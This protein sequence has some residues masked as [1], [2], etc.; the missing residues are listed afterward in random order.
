MTRKYIHGVW[1][2]RYWDYTADEF[3][4]IIKGYDDNDFPIDNLVMD[5]GWHT[6]DATVGTGHNAH[7]NWNGY[8]WNKALIPDP[9]ALVKPSTTKASPCRST[10]IPT[11]A[12]VL[13]NGI[14]PNLPKPLAQKTAR[15]PCSTFPTPLT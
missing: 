8:T 13:T 10:T 15:C 1:Y 11:T 5:M 6:N 12:S 3:L 7:L 2:C 14:M 9:E 4:D